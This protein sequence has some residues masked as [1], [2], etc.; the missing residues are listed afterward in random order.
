MILGQREENEGVWWKP[1]PGV[2]W[3]VRHL[4]NRTKIAVLHPHT[5]NTC[6]DKDRYILAYYADRYS[7][8]VPPASLQS[9]SIIVAT[10]NKKIITT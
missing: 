4:Q 10:D 7:Y 8:I 5:H 3:D 1:G 2:N 9:S 6:H